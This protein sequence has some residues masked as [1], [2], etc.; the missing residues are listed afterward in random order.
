MTVSFPQ[1]GMDF[2]VDLAANNQR[3]WFQANKARY[4]AEL[5]R[6][7]QAL[8]EALNA[9][10]ERFSADHV[11]P[12]GK[13]LRRIHRDTRFSKDKTPYNTR[14]WA[15]FHDLSRPKGASAGFYLGI[16]PMGVGVGAGLWMAPKDRL[17]G[18]LGAIAQQPAQ[19]VGLLDDLAADYGPPQGDKLKRVP[20]PWDADHAG[21]EQLKHK[22]LYLKRDLGL[23]LATSPELVPTVAGC[24]RELLPLV[25]YLDRALA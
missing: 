9:E 24:F 11:T 19:L 5:K 17:A 2:L 4:E 10:L 20:R 25:R 15:G 3:D 7:A 14:I 13:A 12:P 16:S 8:V 18:L 6:P 23:E 22:G 1:G 21:A